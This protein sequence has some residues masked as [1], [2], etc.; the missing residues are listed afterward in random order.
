MAYA[1]TDLDL[2]G[3][4]ALITGASRGIGYAIAARLAASGARVALASRKLEGLQDAAGKIVA[5]GN[6]E[7]LILAA[8][9]SRADEARALIPQVIEA[10]GG[11]DVLVNNAGSNPSFGPLVD[12][13]EWAWDKTLATNLKGPFL[14]SQVAGKWMAENGGGSII[15]IASVGGL[16]PSVNLGAYSVSK[17]GIIM[18]TKVLAAELGPKGV[19]VN[20]IAPGLV[21]TRFADHLV[22]TPEIHGPLV[23]KAALRRHGQ[24]HEISGAA[25]FL[26][27]EASSF[28]TG[29]VMVIDGGVRY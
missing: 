11:I 5:A 2:T 12:L 19:R 6:A 21:E 4:R 24:P 14:L 15:N 29:Q 16:D 9:V 13:E 18:L 27:S 20:C 26:A 28:M 1:D 22:T 23:A 10:W 17:A 3:K 7:P 8:N 25:H